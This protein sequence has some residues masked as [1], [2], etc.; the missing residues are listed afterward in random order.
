MLVTMTSLHLLQTGEDGADLQDLSSPVG[1]SR[2]RSSLRQVITTPLNLRR[3]KFV[4]AADPPPEYHRA[5]YRNSPHMKK[6]S[7]GSIS[8][9]METEGYSSG[10]S[11][12]PL[13]M[14]GE[15][16]DPPNQSPREVRAKGMQRIRPRRLAQV[17]SHSEFEV[18]SNVEQVPLAKQGEG[19]E[20]ETTPNLYIIFQL[21]IDVSDSE[22]NLMH[23]CWY[24]LSWV[25]RNSR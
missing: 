19:H 3:R 11:P 24:T 18:V 7:Q 5:P 4:S 6:L 8:D 20:E 25:Y 14:F 23:L 12:L 22:H 15:G 17:Q 2:P 16:G 9:M 10:A 21:C 1:Q 13:R